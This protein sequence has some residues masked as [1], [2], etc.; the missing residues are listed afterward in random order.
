MNP[1]P[2]TRTYIP[3]LIAFVITA[4]LGVIGVMWMNAKF[5]RAWDV[6]HAIYATG[7]LLEACHQH[8]QRTGSWPAAGQYAAKEVEFVRSYNEKGTRVDV[9]NFGGGQY[10]LF[11]FRENSIEVLP[12]R[13]PPSAT[14]AP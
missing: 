11:Y 5:A 1:M 8:K 7:G 10:A 6:P 3:L 14:S 2:K 4:L 12:V 13:N 9:W